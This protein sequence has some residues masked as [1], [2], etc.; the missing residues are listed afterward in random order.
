MSVF[1][2][3]NNWSNTYFGLIERNIGLI[4]SSEQEKLRITP[5]I[6]FGIG[7]LG[8]PL[9]EQ[10]VRSG[11]ERIIICDDD[12]FQ[13]SN[14]N[15]QICTREDLGKLKVDVTENYLKKINPEIKIQKYYQIDEDNIH[16]MLNKPVIAILTLDDP[17]ASIII[18]R[19]CIER[20]IPLIESWGIPYLWAW[21]FTSESIDYETCY[22]F[23]TKGI[24]IKEIKPTKMLNFREK[25]LLKLMQ[26]PGIKEIYNRKLNSVKAMISG[27]IALVSLAPVVRITASYLAFEVI[28]SGILKTKEMVLAPEIIGYDYFRMEPIKFNFLNNINKIK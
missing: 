26:I 21:W 4:N 18:S 3:K 24:P 11:F 5:I 6:I 9:A 1:K 25:Q 13:E 28:F 22:S 7:G 27:E 17:I 16:E 12:T 23:N 14:L 2:K 20:N 19:A 10:L 15:R 8:G